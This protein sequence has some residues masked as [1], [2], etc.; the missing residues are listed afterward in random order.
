M[1]GR[2][3]PTTKAGET[4]APMLLEQPDGMR[5]AD[6]PNALSLPLRDHNLGASRDPGKRHL[7]NY[8]QL[9]ALRHARKNAVLRQTP[10][11]GERPGAHPEQQSRRLSGQKPFR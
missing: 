6:E 1:R 7:A 2:L 10:K 8:R 3:S 4:L 11:C 9:L 5:V